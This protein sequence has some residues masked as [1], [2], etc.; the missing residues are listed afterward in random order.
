[1]R[2]IL[3]PTSD[4]SRD[5]VQVFPC[6]ISRFSHQGLTEPRE[7]NPSQARQ[8]AGNPNRKMIKPSLVAAYSSEQRWNE[9]RQR[10][11][12]DGQTASVAA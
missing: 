7:K 2:L 9:T 5:L 3:L 11:P 4:K 6:G 8:Q 10:K 1:M 12:A